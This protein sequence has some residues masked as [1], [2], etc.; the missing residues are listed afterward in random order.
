MPCVS[1]PGAAAGTPAA[2]TAATAGVRAIRVDCQL[3]VDR[4]DLRGQVDI[5]LVNPTAAPLDRIYLWLYPNRLD[6]VPASVDDVSFYW[7]YPRRFDPGSMALDQVATGPSAASLRPVPTTGWRAEPHAAAG[8]RT[9]WSIGLPAPLAPGARLHLR[10]T[11]RA[12]VPTRYGGFGCV[13]GGCTLAGGFYPMPAAL[14]AAGWD[15]EAA[16]LPTGLDV[17]VGLARPGSIVLFDQWSGNGAAFLRVRAPAAPYATLVV[18]P[19]LYESRRQV[20][21]AELRF[22]A[23]DPPPPA[24]DASRVI[25]PYTAE[26]H[27]AAALDTAAAA[28]QVLA[29]LDPGLRPRS[30]TMVSAPLR[31]ELATAH[32]RIVLVSDRFFRIWPAERFRKF[33]RRQLARAVFAHQMLARLAGPDAAR[34]D[35]AD[36]VA[37]YLA[38]LFILRRYDRAEYLQNILRPVSFVPAID[39]LLYAPQTMFADAYFGDLGGDL[40]GGGPADPSR[41]DPRRFMHTRPR[42]RLLFEKLRDLLGPR[43][44]RAMRAVVVG[45]VDHRVAAERAHGAPLDWFFRQWALP[46]PRVD[47]RLVSH[48]ARRAGAGY[49]NQVIVARDTEPGDRPPVEPVTVLAIDRDG[50]RH[51][52]RWSGVGPRGALRYRSSSPVEW[53]WVDPDARLVQTSVGRPGQHARFDDRD[54]HPV[55]FVY[56][57]LGVLLNVSDLSAVVAADFTLSRVHD[58]ENELRFVAFT[59]AAVDYGGVASYRR[60]FGREVTPDRLLG[61]AVVSLGASRLDGDFFAAGAELDRS[62]TQVSLGASIGADT[63]VFEFEPLAR[64]DARLSASVTATRLDQIAGAAAS[65]LLSGELGAWTSRTITPRAG[66]TLA[67]ELGAA[68]A[69]GDIESRSQLL[70]AGGADGVRGFAPGALFGRA[71]ASARGEYRHT[72]VHDLDWNLGHYSYARGFGGVAFVDAGVLSPC[73]SYVPGRGSVYTSAGYGLE[74]FYDNFGTLASLMRLDLAVRLSG[75]PPS[76]LGETP[77]GGTA[78]QLYLTFL[79]P[80]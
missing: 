80:F 8:R 44:D 69:L 24:G 52:L 21:G 41:D 75:R 73:D 50:G 63:Q 59:S 34:D 12:H 5:S 56:N 7:L 78:V 26:D 28:A 9:L 25:L 67:G 10:A 64:S 20:A 37:S 51:R 60:G 45:G 32:D 14:D 39:Q 76:C 35:A 42:G 15:L 33:H 68:V 2:P 23:L 65:E 77:S 29:D 70:A 57:N 27:A 47:Y 4:G 3:D 74:A 43:V 30:L 13:D 6:R 1:G 36:L 72:F 40:G 46:H 38:D 18:A 66:H 53:A 61:R 19:A 58:L 17:S 62:A 79:P 71:L 22:L 11:Y 54:H 48:R 55:R 16:P 31:A 49:D